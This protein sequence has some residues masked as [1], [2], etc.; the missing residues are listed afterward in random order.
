MWFLSLG[1]SL[2]Y[3]CFVSFLVFLLLFFFIVSV[4]DC[5]LFLLYCH[6]TFYCYFIAKLLL[7]YIDQKGRNENKLVCLYCPWNYPLHCLP[8]FKMTSFWGGILVISSAVFLESREAFWSFWR[9][10]KSGPL[11]CRLIRGMR[12]KW[13]KDKGI[14]VFKWWERKGELTWCHV[15]PYHWL[16]CQWPRSLI[17]C[18]HCTRLSRQLRDNLSGLE[19]DTCQPI[20]DWYMA[21]L[22]PGQRVGNGQW[23]SS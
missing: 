10:S 17:R 12:R 3:C 18:M 13:K 4:F 22:S 21:R 2:Y 23:I 15:A 11:I 1:F 20:N 6:F 5:F 9:S 14:S 7:L 19:A 8:P 16:G